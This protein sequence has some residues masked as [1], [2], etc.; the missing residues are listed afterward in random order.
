MAC[1]FASK[2]N[3]KGHTVCLFLKVFD[4]AIQCDPT[5]I[6]LKA[7]LALNLVIKF[8][9]TGSENLQLFH[10][11]ISDLAKKISVDVETTIL[12]EEII[13]LACN[14]YD[15]KKETGFFLFEQLMILAGI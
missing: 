8:E 9:E 1:F 3:I 13:V 10:T 11:A 14:D 4:R 15:L 7:L 5:N 12:K 2:M 6:E